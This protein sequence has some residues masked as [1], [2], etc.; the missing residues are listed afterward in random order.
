MEFLETLSE[1]NTHFASNGFAND[2]K[3]L[4]SMRTVIIGCVDG[5]VDPA[6]IFE[7]KPGEAVVVR[8][9]GGRINRAL[10]ET[11]MILQTVAN[12]A[13]KP[14]GEG[15]NLIVL[16]HTDCGIIPCYKH[17]PELLAKHLDVT[18]AQLDKMAVTDPYE[19]VQLDVA[20]LKANPV[21]PA[22]FM[23]SGVVYDVANGTISTVVP[24]SRL[25]EEAAT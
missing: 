13:G 14:I 15:W 16:H 5:R 23:I 10:L 22:G 11:L 4:P 25:R 18:N 7:L 12:G 19:A 17:A 21:L 6:D 9:V 3:M 20:A 8:N 24:P 2:L 1:R